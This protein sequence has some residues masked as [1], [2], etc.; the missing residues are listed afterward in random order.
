MD[1]ASNKMYFCVATSKAKTSLAP[2][3]I[4]QTDANGKFVESGYIVTYIDYVPLQRW[5]NIALVVKNTSIYVYMDADLYSVASLSDMTRTAVSVTNVNPIIMGTSGDMT[6]G[7]NVNSTSG[8]VSMARFYNFALGQP[9]IAKMYNN[10]PSMASWL[11]YLGLGNYGVR[12]P[13]YEV[14]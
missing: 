1:Q 8:Y 3:S 12:S 2:S 9:D 14:S 5:V 11:A 10:G 13:I 4:I 6:I 7:D